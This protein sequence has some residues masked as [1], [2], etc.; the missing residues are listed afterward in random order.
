MGT[1]VPQVGWYADSQE[2]R[3]KAANRS[4]MCNAVLE[5]GRLATSQ[6]SRFK[7]SNLSDMEMG[8][9]EIQVVLFPYSKDSRIQSAKRSYM[10]S[11]IE[12]EDPFAEALESR[13]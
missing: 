11:A 2:S 6:E 7:S 8:C 1:A 3:F 13:F 12:L 5:G 9:A 4:Y 10:S